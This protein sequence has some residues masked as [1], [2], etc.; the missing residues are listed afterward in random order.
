MSPSHIIPG[1]MTEETSALYEAFFA[2]EE[3]R[4][5][6]RQTAPQHRLSEEQ[7]KRLKELL[8]KARRGIDL[9]EGGLG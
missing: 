3:V 2:L 1:R 7:K 9:I 4:E 5:I 8:S 6:L